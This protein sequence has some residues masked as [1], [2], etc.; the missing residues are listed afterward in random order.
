MTSSNETRSSS[1]SRPL[2]FPPSGP[3]QRQ[4]FDD[5][6]VKECEQ[7]I[8]LPLREHVG[9]VISHCHTV[10]SAAYLARPPSPPGPITKPSLYPLSYEGN[11][12][13][14]LRLRPVAKN[15]FIGCTPPR[16]SPPASSRDAGG[17]GGSSP[18]GAIKVWDAQTGRETLTRKK[19][20][21]FVRRVSFSP[22]G[23]RIVS[24][25]FDYT[26]KVWDI[27]SLG[28]SK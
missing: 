6:L 12:F 21:G 13:D 22:D 11:C 20:S 8:E 14:N 27:S 7:P 10:G 26:L 1:L 25:G 9:V 23:K 28:T 16:A 5:G 3:P 19:L 18:P 24:G 2:Q 4:S 15:R 17:A